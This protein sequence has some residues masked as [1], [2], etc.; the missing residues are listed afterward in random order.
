MVWTNDQVERFWDYE[1]QRPEH[2]FTRQ[3]GPEIVRMLRSYLRG[4]RRVLDYGC[5]TGD[6]IPHLL[7][8]GYEV[9]G[10]EPSPQ[11]R[12]ATDALV[13]SCE[14]FHGVYDLTQLRARGDR[15]DAILVIEV[16]EHL[17][18]PALAE[19]LAT[20]R[21]FLAPHGVVIFTT[22]HN[23]DL[24]ASFIRC[25][26]CATTFHR[27]QH[28]RSWT[29]ASLRVVMS[30]HVLTT[31]QC[32]MTDFSVSWRLSRSRYLAHLVRHILRI[33]EPAPHL[34]AV[35]ESSRS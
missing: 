29:P 21:G 14:R 33:E 6:L 11:S 30:D 25:P 23:E 22:P 7:A 5:G 15:F 35:C 16:I 12:A 19:L 26:N 27:W 32:F 31:R 8:E 24:A 34:I 18:D 4:Q 3:Y 2:Y 28:V 1:S 10:V 20:V 9:T 13:G 17:D